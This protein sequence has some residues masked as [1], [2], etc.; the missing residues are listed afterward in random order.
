[1]VSAAA[2]GVGVR[3][4]LWMM[5]PDNQAVLRLARRA[6][7]RASEVDSVIEARTGLAQ[8]Q[9]FDPQYVEELAARA[10]L[11]ESLAA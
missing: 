1:M 7:L 11:G 4:L 6:G 10:R 2:E 9:G 5:S 8:A 3:E